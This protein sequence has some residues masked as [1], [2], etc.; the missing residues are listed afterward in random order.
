L[1]LVEDCA[2]ALRS[3]WDAGDP[4]SDAALFS[5]G[6]IKTSPALG[7]SIAYVRDPALRARMQHRQASWPVQGRKEYAL[8]VL[9]FAGLLALG[10]PFVY[11]LF[12]RAG[13]RAGLTS[14]RS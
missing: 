1:V 14:M 6:S 5:F 7:G 9:R 10:R 13:A 3:A 2:Q 4:R 11:E 12:V 8:R